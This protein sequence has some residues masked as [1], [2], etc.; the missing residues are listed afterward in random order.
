MN[1][2]QIFLEKVFPKHSWFRLSA[3]VALQALS[4][5]GTKLLAKDWKHHLIALPIDEYIPFIPVFIIPYVVCYAHWVINFILSAH[6]GKE[7]FCKFALA[8]MLSQ[9]ICGI[10][11]LI[12]PTTIARPDV[13]MYN[14]I[15]GVLLKFIYGMDT[16]VNLFPSMHCLISWFSWIAIRDCD[17]IPKWYQV[18]SLIFGI[19]VCIS[20]VTIKQHFF[21]D[22]IGG[23]ALAEL[24]WQLVKPRQKSL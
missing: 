11:F 1:K 2:T 23:V 3:I 12:M 5:S 17:N 10:V 15:V 14:G 22:I 4:Y 6:T 8:V 13:S 20:T 24:T 7:R 19:I 16:P 21:I 9:I 18:A